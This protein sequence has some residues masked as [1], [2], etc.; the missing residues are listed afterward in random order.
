[1]DREEC[2]KRITKDMVDSKAV[3]PYYIERMQLYLSMAYGIGYNH[4]SSKRIKTKPV[5]MYNSRGSL[6]ERYPS[7]A[8]ASIDTGIERTNI[9][10]VA[11][12]DRE[13][14]GGYYWKYLT[15]EHHDKNISRSKD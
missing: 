14:A 3:P 11:R 2:L 6:L 1:M 9:A 12:G 8:K 4:S 15:S 10:Q 7:V 13:T 5:G